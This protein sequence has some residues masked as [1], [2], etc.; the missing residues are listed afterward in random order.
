MWP[1]RVQTPAAMTFKPSKQALI[2][3]PFSVCTAARRMRHTWCQCTLQVVDVSQGAPQ[4]VGQLGE[5]PTF[6]HDL[7][8]GATLA[9]SVCSQQLALWHL[10][11]RTKAWAAD[12]STLTSPGCVALCEERQLLAAY[13]ALPGQITSSLRVYSTREGAQRGALVKELPVTAVTH[14]VIQVTRAGGRVQG[15]V[16]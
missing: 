10:P 8:A 12:I 7:T 1:A 5:H 13:H 16:L 9:A 15:Q 3:R 6:L 2:N 14:L 11:T 4:L